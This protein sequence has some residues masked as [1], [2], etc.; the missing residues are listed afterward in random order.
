VHGDRRVAVVPPDLALD[1]LSRVATVD[2]SLVLSDNLM[3]SRLP[4]Q[5]LASVGGDLRITDNPSLP[6]SETDRLV[7]QLG[8]GGVGG[9]V[10]IGGNQPTP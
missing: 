6:V 3:L 9:Q 10:V 1:G 4:L 2:G 5:A 8:P 7:D